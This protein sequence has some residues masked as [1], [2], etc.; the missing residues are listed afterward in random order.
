MHQQEEQR[1]RVSVRDSFQATSAAAA[2]GLVQPSQTFDNPEAMSRR[3]KRLAAE[4]GQF[5]H[6]YERK[7]RPGK[8]E[9]ND[10][11]YDR[12]VEDAVKRMD[13]EELDALLRGEDDS[14][15]PVTAA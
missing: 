9:P 13:P 3:Q 8:G 6:Q 10:R 1:R 14:D 4:L 5:M 12:K 15:D 2:S 7:K 11:K